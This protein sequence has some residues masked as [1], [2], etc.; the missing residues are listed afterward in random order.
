MPAHV[1]ISGSTRTAPIR[2]LP[3]ESAAANP[4][5]PMPRHRYLLVLCALLLSACSASIGEYRR[6]E[7]ALH[8][9]EFFQGRLHAHGVIQNYR[10]KVIRRF[11]AE[12]IG[13]WQGDAG[14]LDERFVY[15]DG[16][17]QYRCWRLLKSGNRYTG[18]AGDVVGEARGETRGNA[19]NW[20]YTLRVPVGGRMLKI[21]LDDWLYLIDE[22]HLINRTG[23]RYFGLPVGDITLSIR[24][25]NRLDT[26]AIAP[27]CHL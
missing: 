3:R 8:L 23:M 1:L 17:V 21:G 20:R 24:S 26:A 14:V 27:D 7:P 11:T 16:E 18:T 12:I 5:N 9:D 25:V 15:D 19:L 4:A 6:A 2:N 10:G 13:N 22:R